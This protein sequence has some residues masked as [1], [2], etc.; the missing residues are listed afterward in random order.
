MSSSSGHPN[1]DESITLGGGR[2]ATPPSPGGATATAQPGRRVRG[3]RATRSLGS[4]GTAGSVSSGRASPTTRRSAEELAHQ[5]E[6][7]SLQRP[8]SPPVGPILEAHQ[9]QLED[10]ARLQQQLEALQ[11]QAAATQAAAAPTSTPSPTPTSPNTPAT[12]GTQ[13]GAAMPDPSAPPPSQTAA[14]RPA[15]PPGFEQPASWSYRNREDRLQLPN[16]NQAEQAEIDRINRSVAEGADPPPPTTT[17]KGKRQ[18][19]EREEREHYA[20]RRRKEE[21]RSRNQHHLEEVYRV[22]FGVTC[23]DTQGKTGGAC[24]KGTSAHSFNLV[25]EQ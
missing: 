12:S 13:A 20:A 9:R 22:N 19:T 3:A 15:V 21:A 8:P 2:P 11:A 18:M 4:R 23:H 17:E 16:L 10:N 5:M 7:Q 14:G 25:T 24:T 1:N 6:A